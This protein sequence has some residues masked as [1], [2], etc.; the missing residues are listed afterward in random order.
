M[1][2]ASAGILYFVAWYILTEFQKSSQIPSPG[3]QV[4]AMHSE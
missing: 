1:K 2:L 3:L 4:I